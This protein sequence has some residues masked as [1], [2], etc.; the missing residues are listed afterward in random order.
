MS[1]FHK[2]YDRLVNI[3][4]F[5][6]KYSYKF[7]KYIPRN[8][9]YT[10]VTKTLP[11][12]PFII[13]AT[14][15]VYCRNTLKLFRKGKYQIVMYGNAAEFFRLVSCIFTH[16]AGKILYYAEIMYKSHMY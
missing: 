2:A 5:L 9:R 15:R 3:L 10:V 6:L 4:V 16:L 1:L 14:A 8:K 12:F 11:Q 13:I 7:R